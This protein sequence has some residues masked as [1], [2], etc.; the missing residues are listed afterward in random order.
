MASQEKERLAL[1]A[2]HRKESSV[3]ARQQVADRLVIEEKFRAEALDKNSQRVSRGLSSR[4]DMA[5]AQRVALETMKLHARTNRIA[6]R[7]LPA[8][9]LQAANAYHDI[10][11]AEEAKLPALREALNK[12]RS[13]NLERAGPSS[14][15]EKMLS[16]NGERAPWSLGRPSSKK[17][18]PRQIVMP[19]ILD[20]KN[21]RLS[22]H[23]RVVRQAD[24]TKDIARKAITAGRTLT[25]AERTNAPPEVRQ[26][27]SDRERKALAIRHLTERGPGREKERGKGRSGG[28]RGR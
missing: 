16:S 28:G 12:M 20:H 26:R 4:Q 18:D 5:T 23:K 7:A 6:G 2:E 9:P 13:K 22:A 21:D 27:L 25:D 1:K 10:A 8:N 11:R 24:Q 15:V 3:L 19:G 14:F 17:Q